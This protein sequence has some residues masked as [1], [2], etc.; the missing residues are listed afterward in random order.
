[1][2]LVT[3][4]IQNNSKSKLMVVTCVASL[5]APYVAS[6]IK[7]LIMETVNKEK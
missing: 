7:T 1:M 4:F 6:G 2:D 3:K 5:I